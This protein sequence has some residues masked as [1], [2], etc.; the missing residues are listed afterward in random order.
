[1]IKKI[2]LPLSI[3]SL[4]F[5]ASCTKNFKYQRKKLT[6]L[7]QVTAS[8]ARTQQ[9]VTV[10]A[11]KFDKEYCKHYFNQ[12]NVGA[13]PIQIGVNNQSDT[14]WVL[15]KDNIDLP[16]ENNEHVIKNVQSGIGA[17]LALGFLINPFLGGAH[18]I[19]SYQA[20]SKISDDMQKKSMQMALNVKPKKQKDTLV[21][22]SNKVKFRRFTLT[23]VD[24]HN[25]NNTMDV[26]LTV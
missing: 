26:N 11:K 10:Y 22:V 24:A 4:V 2:I 16:L 6:P 18:S 17:S 19:A 9:N 1:M 14:E 15:L 12:S 23:L 20:N 3:I 5:I 8:C 21:F 13:C 7:N 25:Q